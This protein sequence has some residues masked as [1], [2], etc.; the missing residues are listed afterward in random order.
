MRM[1]PR[2]PTRPEGNAMAIQTL[3]RDSMAGETHSAVT[4]PAVARPVVT[5]P[6][7]PPMTPPTGGNRSDVVGAD[8]T[9]SGVQVAPRTAAGQRALKRRRARISADRRPPSGMIPSGHFTAAVVSA[10]HGHEVDYRE[11]R[12]GRW[13]RLVCTVSL[14]TA[15]VVVGVVLLSPG[16]PE[17]IG[18]V[19]V[20][21]GDT[22]WSIA[23]H[24]EPEADVR[25]V[26]DRIKDLNALTGDSI[27]A[28]VALRV[29]TLGH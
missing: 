18:V 13:A 20:V 5:R 10:D 25:A 9:S 28:G 12:L 7:T 29:P 21:P 6:V 14:L 11:F 19:T 26:V 27:T 4:H 24:A 1:R 22:L 15:V 17:V 3:H 8:P 2:P 16:R 23:R